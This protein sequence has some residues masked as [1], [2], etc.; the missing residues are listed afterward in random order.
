MSTLVV[1]AKENNKIITMQS[2]VL[3][4]DTRP[5]SAL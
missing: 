5:A 2:D 4:R 1:K 3:T